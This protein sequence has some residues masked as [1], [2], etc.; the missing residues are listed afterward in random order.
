MIDIEGDRDQ[1]RDQEI[2]DTGVD[3]D[4]DHVQDPETDTQEDH[5]IDDAIIVPE[6]VH[7]LEEG[8]VE[9]A[10]EV[11]VEAAIDII[12]EED[13]LKT[14]SACK[15]QKIPDLL[16][17]RQNSLI[18]NQ[19]RF[20]VPKN[21]L[22]KVASVCHLHFISSGFVLY[23]LSF[24]NISRAKILLLSFSVKNRKIG[25]ILIFQSPETAFWF[26]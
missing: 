11:E 9:N 22:Y 5:H 8:E 26:Y 23:R 24:Q 18:K 20:Q 4:L 25:L 13:N 10:P 1:G 15:K 12:V 17:I 14:F 19:N 7:H 16:F 6:L 3:L 21:K 2:E